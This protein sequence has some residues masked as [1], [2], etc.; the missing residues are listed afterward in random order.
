VFFR[1]DSWLYLIDV[2]EGE[3][4]AM[5]KTTCPCGSGK[6]LS[7]CCGALLSGARK[8]ET[9]E[10]LMRSRYSA[11][12]LKNVDY[13]VATTW[14]ASR[15]PDLADSIRSW[16]EQVQW[17]RLHVLNSSAD[18]VEFVAEYIANGKPEM[19]RERSVFKMKKGAWFYVGEE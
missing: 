6:W 7:E 9:A 12:V 15:T 3:R 8:A 19:H 1:I 13:L 16:M 10:Q 11:Y 4:K 14:P 17:L 2:L 18:R 5:N